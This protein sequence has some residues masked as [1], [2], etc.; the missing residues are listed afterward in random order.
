MF[1]GQTKFNL[2]ESVVSL[3]LFSKV[4]AVLCFFQFKIN[5]MYKTVLFNLLIKIEVY[6]FIE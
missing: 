5:N 4:L 1:F 2:V 6:Y 3:Y